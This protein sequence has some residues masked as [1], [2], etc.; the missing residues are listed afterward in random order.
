ML[1]QAKVGL[2]IGVANKRSI[3]WA[4]AQRVA[5]QGA[6]LVL[7]YQNERL[8]EKVIE[9]AK[10]LDPQ[11]V[12]LQLDVNDDEQIS[13]VFEQIRDKF[14]RLDFLVHSVAFA[15]RQ[16]LEG[17]YINTSREGYRIALDV[18]AYSLTALARAAQPLMTDGGAI[19][20][21]SYLGAERVIPNYNVMGVAK[22]AL[23]ASVRYLANDLGQ[24]G[25]RVNALSAGPVKTLAASGISGFSRMLEHHRNKAPLRKNTE[26]SEIA[27]AAL[28]L[29][30][31]LSRGITGQ[32]IYVDGGYSIVGM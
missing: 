7:S 20:T 17:N 13:A 29:L 6:T 16:E 11:P 31:S 14:G 15:P 28:F 8:G 3:A 2:V 9:L 23:E 30:S 26:L 25:I 32:T 24:Y 1:M 21:L 19:L 12:L 18:S 5:E 10:T 22:A 4:I 27:D